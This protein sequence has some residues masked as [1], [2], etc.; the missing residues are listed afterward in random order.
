MRLF[1]KSVVAIVGGAASSL[2]SLTSSAS[3][4]KYHSAPSGTII[5]SSIFARKFTF[6]PAVKASNASRAGARQLSSASWLRGNSRLTSTLPIARKKFAVFC[7]NSE[8]DD[9]IFHAAQRFRETSQA[10]V[11]SRVAKNIQINCRGSRAA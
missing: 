1:D 7:S 4:G 3:N 6:D 8:G 5:S 11:L 2:F 10:Y 9:S